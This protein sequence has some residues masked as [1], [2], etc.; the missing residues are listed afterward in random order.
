[1]LSS[2]FGH[3]PGPQSVLAATTDCPNLQPARGP[4]RLGCCLCHTL[5]GSASLLA[6]QLA[7]HCSV[8]LSMARQ[9]VGPRGA[10]L[11]H[12]HVLADRRQSRCRWLTV[13]VRE[14]SSLP[15]TFTCISG[16]GRR[17]VSS[18]RTRRHAER[19]SL[20]VI[21][22]GLLSICRGHRDC[23]A[24]GTVIVVYHEC[25]TYA[26]RLACY[27]GVRYPPLPRGRPA[28]R[29]CLTRIT[30]T[31]PLLLQCAQQAQAMDL[32]ARHRRLHMYLAD[33]ASHRAEQPGGPGA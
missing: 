26:G 14:P 27:S 33:C 30:T 5:R 22:D 11:G 13:L 12:R 16:G 23:R 21:A 25:Q 10:Q 18:C 17:C 4:R 29:Q 24:F 3:P 28:P 2:V 8:C 7:C 20:P 15:G 19:G 9:T 6:R 1:M 31:S 32:E